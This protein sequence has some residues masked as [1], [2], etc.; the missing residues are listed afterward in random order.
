MLYN[1]IPLMDAI[2]AVSFLFAFRFAWKSIPHAGES[3]AYWILLSFGMLQAFAYCLS[4]ML[5]TLGY[6]TAA[7]SAFKPILA[8]ALIVNLSLA[9]ILSYVS[10]TRPFD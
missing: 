1:L 9:A 4:S 10:V 6:N 2:G 3:R 7:F 8:A 5:E